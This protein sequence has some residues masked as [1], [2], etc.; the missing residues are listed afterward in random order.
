MRTW[1]D[2]SIVS[3]PSL[4]YVSVLVVTAQYAISCHILIPVCVKRRPRGR[5]NIHIGNP[6]AV[7]RKAFFALKY[8]LHRNDYCIFFFLK[9]VRN[10]I[11]WGKNLVFM[12]LPTILVG[13]GFHTETT[14]TSLVYLIKYAHGFVA[15]YFV[16]VYQDLVLVD[17]YHV[18]THIFHSFIHSLGGCW[19]NKEF[20]FEQ[21]SFS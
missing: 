6:C 15:Q 4:V 1:C 14:W 10:P 8:S 5:L 17:M 19:Y 3:I 2:V 7:P 21:S 12:Y 16:V 13:Q 11:C 18:F 9:H 20:E